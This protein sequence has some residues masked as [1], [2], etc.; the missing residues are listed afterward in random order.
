MTSQPECVAHVPRGRCAG[1]AASFRAAKSVLLDRE[2]R[3]D[4][5]DRSPRS[6]RR[7]RATTGRNRHYPPSHGASTG[8]R[9]AGATSDRA[10]AQPALR[11][12]RLRRLAGDRR[13]PV[14][15]RLGLHPVSRPSPASWS[16]G[17]CWPSASTR[18]AG[19]SPPASPRQPAAHDLRAAE[20]GRADLFTGVLLCLLMLLW[21]RAAVIIYALFFGLLPFPGLDHIAAMLFT[22]PTGWAMLL[23]GSVVGALFAAFSFAISVFSDSDAARR[24]DRRPHRHGHQHGAGLEQ[25][26]GDAGLGRDRAGAVPAQP[27]HRPARA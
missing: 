12:R 21:M 23:V 19:A 7:C 9:R 8:W 1:Q 20:V 24:A 11:P 2:R 14:R 26:A 10:R 3:I 6:C 13:R 22:T 16:S 15:L 25:S 4:D 5:H 27:G 18:R 17:R